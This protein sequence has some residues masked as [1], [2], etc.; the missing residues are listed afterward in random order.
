MVIATGMSYYNNEISSSLVFR[1]KY[2]LIFHNVGDT[3]L[4]PAIQFSTDTLF[5][6]FISFMLLASHFLV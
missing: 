1:A 4:L 5:F 2:V 3:G 6:S